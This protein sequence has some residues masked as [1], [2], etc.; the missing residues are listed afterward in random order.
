MLCLI[1]TNGKAH[2][3]HPPGSKLLPPSA[4]AKDWPLPAHQVSC[5][6]AKKENR[7]V[8]LSSGTEEG[9]QGVLTTGQLPVPSTF[10][11]SR[12]TKMPPSLH[13]LLSQVGPKS[14]FP[15][16]PSKPAHIAPASERRWRAATWERRGSQPYVCIWMGR[17]VS[18]DT[19]N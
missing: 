12:K 10:P 17:S 13:S 8:E 11:L 15:K 16:R 3:S 18:R 4:G 5:A 9:G 19:G 2:N 6:R 1:F 14:P 7:H